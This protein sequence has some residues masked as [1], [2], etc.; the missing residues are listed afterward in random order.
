MKGN[1]SLQSLV[2]PW[3]RGEGNAEGNGKSRKDRSWELYMP[4]L[5]P[6]SIRGVPYVCLVP[7]S[8]VK[9]QFIWYPFK[10]MSIFTTGSH[11]FLGGKKRLFF[12]FGFVLLLAWNALFCA[13]LLQA[14]RCVVLN[15]LQKHQFREMMLA[16]TFCLCLVVVGLQSGNQFPTEGQFASGCL[17]DPQSG[18]RRETGAGDRQGSSAFYSSTQKKRAENGFHCIIAEFIVGLN[19]GTAI[20]LVD[21]DVRLDIVNNVRLHTPCP[22]SP[23]LAPSDPYPLPH[24]LPSL[25]DSQLC[26]TT[27]QKTDKAEHF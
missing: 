11:I 6:E 23:G 15:P 19:G 21:P 18:G 16:V 26:L 4:E 22:L 1:L 7:Q 14:D 8:L 25:W 20:Q 5:H 24:L 3:S 13:L 27:G 2:S 12:L 17:W 9:R 10:K